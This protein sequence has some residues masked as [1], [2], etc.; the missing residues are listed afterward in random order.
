MRPDG[1]SRMTALP[2]TSQHC[3]I[4]GDD[5]DADGSLHESFIQSVSQ[6][7]IRLISFSFSFQLA[8]SSLSLCAYARM[9]R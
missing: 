4:G 2:G 9:G 7:V 6:A 3:G 1:C 5:A 8:A